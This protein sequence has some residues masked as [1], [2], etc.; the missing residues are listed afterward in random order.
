MSILH[1]PEC[2]ACLH[3]P[4]DGQKLSKLKLENNSIKILF[5]LRFEYF[6]DITLL[7]F[8][9][10]KWFA[11]QKYCTNLEFTCNAT[12]MHHLSKHLISLLNNSFKFKT[13]Q[14]LST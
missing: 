11:L 10:P 6:D 7:N 8:D 12:T 1:L 5:K 9:S 2:Q 13:H 14:N 3:D 4:I